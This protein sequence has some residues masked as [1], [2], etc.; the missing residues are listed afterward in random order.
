MEMDADAATP[1]F[2]K[3]WMWTGETLRK[4]LSLMSNGR[5]PR[6]LGCSTAGL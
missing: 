5:F 1:M 4:I 6:H 3:Y 2:R